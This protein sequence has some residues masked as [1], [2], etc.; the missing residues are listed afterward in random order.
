VSGQITRSGV[1]AAWSLAK[2]PLPERPP[3]RPHHKVAAPGLTGYLHAEDHRPLH[4]GRRNLDPATQRSHVVGV[5]RDAGPSDQDEVSAEPL[6]LDPQRGLDDHRI[7]EVELYV[8][9]NRMDLHPLRNHP[10]ADP[11]DI[12]TYVVD[13]HQFLG[14]L[15]DT[16]LQASRRQV[17]CQLGQIAVYAGGQR[18]LQSLVKLGRG[19]PAVASGD[20]QDSTTWSR[21]SCEARS[22]G[23]LP[24]LCAFLLTSVITERDTGP[25]EPFISAN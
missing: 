2:Q 6:R 9:A 18:R 17:G 11:L 22:S 10:A 14:P 19:Q 7:G 5:D 1:A 21:S 8:A 13:P 15:R 20:P 24:E 3:R 4:G 12:P 16:A 25:Y 23:L